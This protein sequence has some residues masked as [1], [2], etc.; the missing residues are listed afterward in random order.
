MQAVLEYPGIHLS[1][2][3]RHVG[4]RPA[5]AQHHLR[6]LEDAR[7]ITSTRDERYQRFWPTKETQFGSLPALDPSE[8]E[9]LQY[10]RRP[11][12][13]RIL[14][15]LIVE[16]P[17]Q[18]SDLARRCRLAPSTVHGHLKRLE[19]AGLVHRQEGSRAAPWELVDTDLVRRL[20]R[21]YEPP[22]RLVSGFLDVWSRMGP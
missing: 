2:L 11:P 18:L 13:L 4:I 20:L 10:T 12:M 9:L 7:G 22:P 14:V 6:A 15:N 17:L 21:E 1:E 3:C 19:A 8:R 16:G 5:H